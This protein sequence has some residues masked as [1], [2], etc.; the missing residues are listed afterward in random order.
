MNKL[1]ILLVPLLLVLSSAKAAPTES[2]FYSD[3]GILTIPSVKVGDIY[4]YDAQLRLNNAG[5]FDLVGYSLSPSNGVFVDDE[6]RDKHITLEK[7]QQI[8]S[9]MTLE[10]VNSIVGCKGQLFTATPLFTIYNWSEGGYPEIQVV[11]NS[12]GVFNPRYTPGRN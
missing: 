8:K 5:S 6:C 12:D 7:Y 9:G 1:K 3:S 10:Q 2:E 4:V 11:I